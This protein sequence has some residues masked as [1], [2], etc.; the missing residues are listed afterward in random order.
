[1]LLGI[2]ITSLNGLPARLGDAATVAE[3]MKN[4]FPTRNK[5]AEGKYGCPKNL[6]YCWAPKDSNPAIALIGD[7]HAHHLAFGLEKNLGKSFLLIGQAGTPP[8]IDLICLRHEKKSSKPLMTQ[9]LDIVIKDTNIK[10]V[11]LSSRW[12]LFTYYKQVPYL[13]LSSKDED[14]R[15]KVL[16]KL[17][18]QTIEELIRN[19]KKVIIL[20]DIP[21]N[22]LNPKNCIKTRPLQ[23]S[24]KCSFNESKS[25]PINELTNE[26]ILKV[27]KSYPSVI[28]YDPSKALCI[29]GIC[30]I[31]KSDSIYYHDKS[32]LTNKGSEI[33]TKN[34][35]QHVKL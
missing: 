31:G 1:M 26:M 22:P 29:K 4:T 7:S 6:N 35:I 3:T 9:A 33:V 24:S 27:A 32:H 14:N 34:I 13:W 19:K 16:E 20:L 30:T 17:L 2:L 5:Y 15:L 28:V 23:L 11:I 12:S 21:E 18:S 10:T 25:K 8:V